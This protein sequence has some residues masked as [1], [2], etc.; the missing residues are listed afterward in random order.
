M[1]DTEPSEVREQYR[2]I[3][4]SHGRWEEGK[5]V[6]YE[7]GDLI[8]LTP[9]EVSGLRKRVVK[10]ESPSELMDWS[11]VQSQTVP[12]VLEVVKGLDDIDSL[13]ALLESEKSGANRIGVRKG[14]EER[15]K[16]L[17]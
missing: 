12:E 4:G 3:S 9:E 7:K 5:Q 10:I 8:D 15:I 14:V 6:I 16:E 2:L 13:S 1:S 17:S 11:F